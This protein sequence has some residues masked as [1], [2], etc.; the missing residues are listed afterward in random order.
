MEP[1]TPS[2]QPEQP[3]NPQPQVEPVVQQFV[4][5][6]APGA[7]M[8]QPMSQQPMQA[9]P[10]PGHGLGIASLIVSV[11]GFGLIGLILGIIGLNKSKKAG[12]TNVMAIIGIAWGAFSGLIII[13]IMAA[14]VLNNFQGAQIRARDTQA[15]TNLNSL[16]AKLEERYN[17]VNSYPKSISADV[18]PSIDT[19]AL[20]DPTGAS[21]VVIDGSTIATETEAK[22]KPA[23]TRSSYYQYIPFGCTAD[24]CKGYVLR[25]FIEKPSGYYL[26]PYTKTG[27]QNP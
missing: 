4:P 18:F 9:T 15:F 6:P 20:K 7:P 22:A 19:E 1:Q 23:P 25:T 27:L 11:L 17:E 2:T 26:N 16:H 5:A 10:D 14:L 24:A 12:H 3:A 13:P 21:I 8:G